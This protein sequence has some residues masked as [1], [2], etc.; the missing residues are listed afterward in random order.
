MGRRRYLRTAITSVYSLIS[1]KHKDDVPSIDDIHKFLDAFI[2]YQE[3]LNK[4]KIKLDE[5]KKK[6]L[7]EL[8]EQGIEL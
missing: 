2:G 3:Y 1:H 6:L 5:L 4:L 7:S 8:K